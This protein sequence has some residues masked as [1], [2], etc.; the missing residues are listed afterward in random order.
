L[1]SGVGAD[2]M[3]YFA[4][5]LVVTTPCHLVRLPL[6]GEHRYSVLKMETVCFSETLRVCTESQ[7]APVAP[8]SQAQA[9]IAWT[10]RSWVRLPLKAWMFVLVYL[11]SSFTCR[12]IIDTV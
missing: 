7:P 9:L 4:W 1:S 2:K 11:V 8:R 12:P 6:L 5:N 3:S 10:L